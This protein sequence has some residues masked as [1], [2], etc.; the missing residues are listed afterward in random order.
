[1]ISIVLSDN[2]YTFASRR[3]TE[4]SKSGKNAANG[5]L[6]KSLSQNG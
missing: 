3:V 2:H 1:M 6:A 4:L 5:T